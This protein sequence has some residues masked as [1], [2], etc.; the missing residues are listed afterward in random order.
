MEGK[1]VMIEE[2]AKD[3]YLHVIVD[4]FD[5]QVETARGFLKEPFAN[6]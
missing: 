3:T 1:L 6:E 4:E 5:R 2:R